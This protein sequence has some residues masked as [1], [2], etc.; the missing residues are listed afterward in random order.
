MSSRIKFSF[1]CSYVSMSRYRNSIRWWVDGTSQSNKGGPLWQS[2]AEHVSRLNGLDSAW[3]HLPCKHFS[4]HGQEYVGSS[5]RD[6]GL[7]TWPNSCHLT[8]SLTRQAGQI[9]VVR[10]HIWH[11]PP[12]QGLFSLETNRKAE[13][14]K[15]NISKNT[16][17][18]EET[19][20]TEIRR[21]HTGSRSLT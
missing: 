7:F 16:T 10:P 5:C 13:R 19:A 3:F 21:R 8:S 20:N 2:A 9:G 6:A 18:S 17:L 14:E 15:T 1:S 12:A 11:L 4:T